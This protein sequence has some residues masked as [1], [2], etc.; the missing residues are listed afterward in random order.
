MHHYDSMTANFCL[1]GVIIV[2][3]ILTLIAFLLNEGRPYCI[4]PLLRKYCPTCKWVVEQDQIEA[5]GEELRIL[6]IGMAQHM[7]GVKKPCRQV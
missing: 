4:I 6:Q 3:I 1:A 2:F 7:L 5:A